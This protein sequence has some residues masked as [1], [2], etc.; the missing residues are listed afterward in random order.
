MSDAEVESLDGISTLRQGPNTRGW[1]GIQ[2]TTGLAAR[3]TT[4]KLPFRGL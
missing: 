4:A 3:N 2:Y 1:N